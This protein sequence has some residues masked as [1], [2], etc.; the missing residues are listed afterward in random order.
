MHEPPLRESLYLQWWN[1]NTNKQEYS[2]K[3]MG[4]YKVNRFYSIVNPI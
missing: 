2:R 4:N 3:G 1:Y